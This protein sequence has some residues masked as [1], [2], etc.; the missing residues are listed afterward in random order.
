MIC[1]Q[2]KIA[3]CGIPQSDYDP[4]DTSCAHYASEDLKRS[5][6]LSISVAIQSSFLHILFRQVPGMRQTE[7]IYRLTSSRDA[8]ASTT[9][10]SQ[11]RLE[12]DCGCSQL[13]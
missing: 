2:L 12:V 6:I 5:V 3:L 7:R 11:L 4:M 1:E 10:I 8:Q 13:W 9:L